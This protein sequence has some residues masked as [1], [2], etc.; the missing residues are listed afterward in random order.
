MQGLIL[1]PLSSL[2]VINAANGRTCGLAGSDRSLE[3][4]HWITGAR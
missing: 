3:I 4:I 1:T 2:D